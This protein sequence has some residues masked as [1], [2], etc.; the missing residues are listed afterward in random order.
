MSL[1]KYFDEKTGLGILSTADAHGVVN[2]A[3]YSRPH[4]MDEHTI[5]F[6]MANR[7]SH[8]NLQ[9]NPHRWFPSC[10]RR[11]RCG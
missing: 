5:A 11:T 2:S 1:Q 4:V 7:L 9:S 6:I 10:E 3:V 8:E